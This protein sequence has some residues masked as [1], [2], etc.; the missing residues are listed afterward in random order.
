MSRSPI[1]RPVLVLVTALLAT[2]FPM[3]VPASADHDDCR[4]SAGSPFLYAGMIF[5][6]SVVE[7]DSV[8]SRIRIETALTRDGVEVDRGRRDCRRRSV[9]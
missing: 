2:V 6:D 3:A 1:A 8:K 9:C 7:C 5:P 4:I